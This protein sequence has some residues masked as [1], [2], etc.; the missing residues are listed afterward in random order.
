MAKTT[1]SSSFLHSASRNGSR[2]VLI[3]SVGIKVAT[4]VILW[5]VLTL[6]ARSS[7]SSSSLK[8]S[9]GLI[10][11]ILCG[12]DYYLNSINKAEKL[13]SSPIYH[14]SNLGYRFILIFSIKYDFIWLIKVYNLLRKWL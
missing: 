8:S 6:L 10:F 9:N 12:F 5:M 2:V 4:I 7:V 13:L 14:K 11:Y 3:A 1:S